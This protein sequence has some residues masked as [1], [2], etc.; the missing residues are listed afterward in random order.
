MMCMPS[1]PI[2]LPQTLGEIELRD[3]SMEIDTLAHQLELKFREQPDLP[4]FILLD[5]KQIV[6][7]LSRLRFTYALSRPYRREI[8]LKGPIKA[9]FDL[10]II[11]KEPLIMD[12]DR[13][14]SVA[15][16]AALARSNHLAYEP[17]IVIHHNKPKIL[18][19]DLLLRLQSGLLQDAVN[20]HE[21]LI[22]DE[23][24]TANQLRQTMLNLEQTRD[25]LQRSEENLEA[26]V[27]QRTLELKKANEDLIAQ[28]RQI[29]EDLEVARTLQQS[30]LPSTFSMNADYQAHA[31]M[32]AARMIGGDFYDAYQINDHQFGFVVADVSGKGVPAA[33]FMILV[34]TILQEQVTHHISPAECIQRLNGQLLLH[35][36]LSLFVTM[37]Y[38]ILDTKTGLFT[39]CN[40]GHPMPYIIRHH[41]T[42]EIVTNKSNPLVGLLDHPLYNNI[43]IQLEH[44][45]RVLLITDGVTECFNSESE[46][47]GE[48]RLLNLLQKSHHLHEIE[49]L[50]NHLI[51]DLDQFSNGTPASDDTTALM[52]QYTKL[53]NHHHLVENPALLKE[54]C[55]N[56]GIFI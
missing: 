55:K 3:A 44:H 10:D 25:R 50:I 36:P 46:A 31:F 37:I 34:K 17:V 48:Q 1:N 2:K 43:S 6:G 24:K 12:A 11:D 47:Y 14:L 32:R 20:L 16:Q 38:G 26:Q 23:R 51:Q 19:I 53:R 42:I 22:H 13:I 9:L 29:N 40:A 21:K 5:K 52:L 30:I 45:D 35:N 33:L 15:V 8:F 56:E 41:Q 54:L 7:V 39:F 27:L 4:G 18:N 49:D 28:Q